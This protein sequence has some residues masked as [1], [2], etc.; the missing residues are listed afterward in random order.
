MSG[1]FYLLAWPQPLEFLWPS[2]NLFCSFAI[3]KVSILLSICMTSWFLV[4]TKQAGKGAHLF[5]CSLLVCL[6]LDINFFP[7]QTIAS[8]RPFASWGYVGIMSTCR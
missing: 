3:A 6:G 8:L 4:L 5:L 1:R 7:S 2:P